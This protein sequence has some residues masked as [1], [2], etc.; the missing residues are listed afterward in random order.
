MEKPR[1]LI[2]GTDSNRNKC[3]A[4]EW[5]AVGWEVRANSWG[6]GGETSANLSIV[7]SNLRLPNS[8]WEAHHAS[9]MLAVI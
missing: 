2:L 8:I 4:S 9:Y 6:F 7:G 5:T 3:E 1:A